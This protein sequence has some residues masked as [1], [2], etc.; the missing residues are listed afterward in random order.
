MTREER[1]NRINELSKILDR[2]FGADWDKAYDEYCVLNAQED[3]DYRAE[4]EDKLLEFYHKHIE[5]KTA[6]TIDQGAWDFY[7]DWHKD[8]YGYRPKGFTI[9][10]LCV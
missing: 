2:T 3:E 9:N 4:N 10:C 6:D 1:R 7:S 5:G 8:V